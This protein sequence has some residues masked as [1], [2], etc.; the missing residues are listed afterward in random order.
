MQRDEI[1]S[2]IETCIDRMDKRVLDNCRITKHRSSKKSVML[3]SL[4]LI[5]VKII[6]FIT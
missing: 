5:V 1:V 3:I 6:N 4:S 2:N